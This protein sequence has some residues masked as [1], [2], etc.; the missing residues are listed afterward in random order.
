MRRD[1]PIKLY[2]VDAGKKPLAA[3]QKQGGI[4]EKSR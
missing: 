2:D 1:L 4:S 3:I